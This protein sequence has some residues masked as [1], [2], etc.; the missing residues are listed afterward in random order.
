MAF[1]KQAGSDVSLENEHG[2]VDTE[3]IRIGSGN[4]SINH[5]KFEV[6]VILVYCN[7]F[8]A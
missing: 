3:V 2:K 1:V 7:I 6:C 5:D 8:P 4:V